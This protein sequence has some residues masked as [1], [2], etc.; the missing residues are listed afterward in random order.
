MYNSEN[1]RN[2]ISLLVKYFKFDKGFGTNVVFFRIF[3]VSK[4]RFD[5]NIAISAEKKLCIDRIVTKDVQEV[6][7]TV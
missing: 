5:L 4:Y 7:E 2:Y 3:R 6:L 1:I